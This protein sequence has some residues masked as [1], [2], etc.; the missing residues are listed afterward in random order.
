MTLIVSKGFMLK[1]ILHIIQVHFKYCRF[2]L[3]SRI[4]LITLMSVMATIKIYMDKELIDAMQDMVI[5]HNEKG[6][7]ITVILFGVIMLGDILLSLISGIFDV[8]ADK[9]Y[10]N[11]I[12]VALIKKLRHLD[13]QK[14]EDSDTKDV[15]MRAS[16]QS[17][18][19]IKSAFNQVVEIAK[20]I[21]SLCGVG[22]ILINVSSGY[23]L[24]LVGLILLVI[25]INYK[26]GDM[27]AEMYASQTNDERELEY[28]NDLFVNKSVLMELKAFGALKFLEQKLKN[29]TDKLLAYKLGL[30]KKI[31]LFLLGKG[32]L[33]SAWFVIT[34]Y[35]TVRMFLNQKISL[36]IFVI[37][38]ETV[39]T[40]LAYCE[41]IS[42][43]ARN[44]SRDAGQSEYLFNFLQLKETV[45]DESENGIITDI[46]CIE[47]RHVSFT[48]P[49]TSRRVLNDISLV[50][51]RHEKIA[52]VGSNGA[53]KST[54]IK[55]L[56][57]LYKPDSG[58]ILINGIDINNIPMSTISKVMGIVF[59][60]YCKYEMTIRENVALGNLRET[61]SNKEIID[62]LRSSGAE[63]ITQKSS[64]G[65]D[66]ALGKLDS[67]G[68]DLS[69]GQWQ[70]LAFAR[71]LFSKASFIILDEPTA[72]LDPVAESNM[73]E[74]FSR[75]MKNHTAL[76]VSHRLGS[77]KMANKILVLDAGK[78]VEEGSHDEL[79]R[80]KG[81][82]SSMYNMQAHWYQ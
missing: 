15:I 18:L 48:Y 74:L 30:I 56:C 58:Q 2:V 8:K 7:I 32:L 53:G 75:V 61:I 71:A 26:I 42:T 11:T 12:E 54:I 31:R 6:L 64:K 27:W 39:T 13:Y 47:F 9:S 65:L 38:L 3:F 69:G 33:C 79:M 5:N 66:T 46:E 70:K 28:Y 76:M 16:E 19:K 10:S 80:T 22:I 40:V 14:F 51:N 52:L 37:A 62:A 25:M 4:F 55:L 77:S 17:Y 67:E 72:S 78:I 1:N 34:G 24:L 68:I 45:P 44:L 43:N 35:I 63:E 21:L 82:Y 81:L 73:Y 49:H 57:K 36:G 60:D 59:Q 23:I 50:I 20:C 41:S 29:K